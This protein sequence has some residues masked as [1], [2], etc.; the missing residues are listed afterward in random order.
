MGEQ[1]EQSTHSRP[2]ATRG[3]G[4]FGN[5]KGDVS[6]GLSAAIIALPV[7]ISCG[8]VAF[9]PLGPGYAASGALAGLYAA[10]FVTVVAALFGGT[11]LQISGP[12]SS[13]AVILAALLA[14]LLQ[15]PALGPEPS[16]RAGTALV[17]VFFCVLLAGVFQVGFSFLR[18]GTIIKFIPYPVTV[19]FMNGLAVIIVLSQVS[20]FVDSP[21]FGFAALMSNA[22][23]FKPKAAAIALASLLTMA[24]ARRWLKG[25]GDAVSALIVGTGVYYFFAASDPSLAASGGLGGIIGRV[26]ADI[27]LPGQ[28]SG[29]IGLMAAPEWPRL[30]WL[31][32]P[33]AFVLA[34]L[35]SIESLLSAVAMDTHSDT[36]HGSNRELLGQGLGNIAAACFGGLAGGGSPTRATASYSAGGRTRLAS[37]VHGLFFLGVVTVAGPLV[38]KIPLAVTAGI[39]FVYA[40]RL[41]DDWT[42][43]LI[44]KVGREK[45]G[46][47]NREFYLNLA[48]VVLVTVLTVAADLI[49]AVG[50]GFAVASFLFIVSAGQSPIYRHFRGSQVHSKNARPLDMMNLL[51]TE[52]LA[53]VVVEAQGPIFFG[54]AERL[55]E[56]LEAF[57]NEATFIILDLRRVTQIDA[58]GAHILTRLDRFMA[59]KGKTLLISHLTPARP[60]WAFLADMD[61]IRPDTENHFFPDSDTAL[62]WAEDRI[63]NKD[64]RGDG[65]DREIPLEDLEVLIGIEGKQLESFRKILTRK[66]FAKGE[67]IFEEGDKG[68]AMYFVAR[69]TLSVRVRLPD[70]QR[71]V[72]LAGIGS[73]VIFGEMAILGSIPRTATVTADEDV[74]CYMLTRE[75]FQGLG[76]ENPDI[77]IRLLLNLSRQS[78]HR[79]EMTSEEVRALER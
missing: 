65:R 10:I 74:V 66:E 73:G 49:V 20:I 11:P 24:V 72:R 37:I 64:M 26:P 44:I 30:V 79:L 35:G 7:A 78:A 13:L 5:L 70:G 19:G 67:C 56:R 25:G 32:V 23:A 62:A 28:V 6:G 43:Q 22:I 41:A 27:P 61:V 14:V 57:A 34:L 8:L 51:K 68:D 12:K 39:L 15:E 33:S 18:L 31:V 53:I 55:A 47:K 76:F 17:L 2:A 75:D 50:V 42:R 1:G 71:S 46:E 40:Y 59:N 29:F 52:G 38:G 16:A 60:M 58:T 9:A 48:V 77:V 45:A 3:S 4:I 69:G 63:L 36:R 54:S 21:D